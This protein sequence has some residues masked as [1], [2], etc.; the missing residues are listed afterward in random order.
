MSCTEDGDGSSE[1]GKSNGK[2]T[3]SDSAT[4]E[5]FR[6]VRKRDRLIEVAYRTSYKRRTIAIN[7]TEDMTRVIVDV[8]LA[9]DSFT[10]FDDRLVADLVELRLPLGTRQVVDRE[11]SE[12]Q[13]GFRGLT[14][15]PGVKLPRGLR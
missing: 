13:R 2:P 14:P 11:G 7:V 5:R 15:V 10:Y 9:S 8:R 3:G 6:S 1:P 12:I 4:I